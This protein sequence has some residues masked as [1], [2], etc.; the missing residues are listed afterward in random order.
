MHIVD[1]TLSYHRLVHVPTCS[2]PCRLYVPQRKL[3]QRSP[4]FSGVV[5][6]RQM[7]NNASS[8]IWRQEALW[9]S[10]ESLVRSCDQILRFSVDKTP[11]A[12]RATCD[13]SVLS[14]S[15]T[16]ACKFLNTSRS[17]STGRLSSS[18]TSNQSIDIHS[19]S[20]STVLEK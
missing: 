13:L 9:R 7:I 17:V 15:V 19:M 1:L 5:S 18:S 14:A 10:L 3:L 11:I 20:I 6:S 2:P 16:M 8:T 4:T 12:P